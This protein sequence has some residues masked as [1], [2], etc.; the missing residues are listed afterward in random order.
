VN[1]W[2]GGIG[3]TQIS[4]WGTSGEELDAKRSD[5]SRVA[6]GTSELRKSR[7]AGG[8]RQAGE[9]VG[10]TGVCIDGWVD[11]GFL[12]VIGQEIGHTEG[13]GRGWAGLCCDA[14]RRWVH[15]VAVG[16]CGGGAVR[17]LMLKTLRAADERGGL[18]YQQ[19]E[20]QHHNGCGWKASGH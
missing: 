6:Y 16:H 11:Q 3:R 13:G 7:G 4:V 19:G 10:G 17:S 14:V 5:E 8:D 15:R 18:G 1:G 20:H 2:R 9:K 12:L